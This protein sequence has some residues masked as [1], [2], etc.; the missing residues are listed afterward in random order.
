MT[1]VCETGQTIIEYNI[2]QYCKGVRSNRV[3]SKGESQGKEEGR[4]PT[5]GNFGG[6]QKSDKNS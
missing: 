2:I 1:E 6:K 4:Y 3:S 5:V